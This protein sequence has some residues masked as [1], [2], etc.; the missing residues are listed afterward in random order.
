MCNINSFYF[1]FKLTFCTDKILSQSNPVTLSAPLPPSCNGMT[2]FWELGC[3]FATYPFKIHSSVSKYKP[4]YILLNI[5][6]SS[7]TIRI[8]SPSCTTSSQSRSAPCEPCQSTIALIKHVQDHVRNLLPSAGLIPWFHYLFFLFMFRD[9]I[10]LIHVY[11]IPYSNIL[12]Q[13]LSLD[14]AITFER[15]PGS[16]FDDAWWQIWLAVELP[17]VD[18]ISPD[19]I[20][21]P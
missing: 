17:T 20:Q 11:N 8:H 21:R 9:S 4:D 18:P 6:G 7:S 2:F 15:W 3:P 14:V 10:N 19:Q 13:W 12:A 16:R 5:D 1:D